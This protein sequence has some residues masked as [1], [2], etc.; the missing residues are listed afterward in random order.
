MLLAIQS[1]REAVRS[2]SRYALYPDDAVL[3]C[4]ANEMVMDMDMFG[5]LV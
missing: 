3:N 2:H 4:L 5:I 1:L